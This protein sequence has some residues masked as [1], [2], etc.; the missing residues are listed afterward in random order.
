MER[1]SLPR[2]VCHMMNIPDRLTVYDAGVVSVAR[3]LVIDMG[4]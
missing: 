3:A 1:A 4:G 2:D